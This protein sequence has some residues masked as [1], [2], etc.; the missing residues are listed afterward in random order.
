MSVSAGIC[1][2]ISRSTVR[3]PT[4]ESNTP[5]GRET[6][7]RLA[8]YQRGLSCPAA[9][10]EAHEQHVAITARHADLALEEA[11]V[12]EPERS[13]QRDRRLIVRKHAQAQLG[14]PDRARPG[15]RHLHE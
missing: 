6:L 15:N 14:K 11:L 1:W 5:I 8:G 9:T 2:R 12:L 3:P 4:P 13:V 10:R 7:I